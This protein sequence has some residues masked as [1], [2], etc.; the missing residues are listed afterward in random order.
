MITWEDGDFIWS[1]IPL[2]ENGANTA[3]A[4]SETRYNDLHAE[5]KCA[6]KEAV[7]YFD[8]NWHGMRNKW[9]EVHPC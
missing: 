1:N 9:N 2:H 3:Y 8:E 4:T 5:F 7:S 6:P